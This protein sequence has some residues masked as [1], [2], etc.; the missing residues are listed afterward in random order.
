MVV[1]DRGHELIG[2]EELV[3]GRDGQA[4]TEN[5][6]NYPECIYL[7]GPCDK[8]R[9]EN[10][11]VT[12]DQDDLEIP[13]RAETFVVCYGPNY[14]PP[15]TLVTCMG[16]NQWQPAIPVCTWQGKSGTELGEGTTLFL[17]TISYIFTVLYYI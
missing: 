9:I 17:S 8:P 15:Q 5:P 11:W 4:T 13:F 1:C 2:T 7:P 10:G 14:G 16:N 3:C 12:Y 6:D